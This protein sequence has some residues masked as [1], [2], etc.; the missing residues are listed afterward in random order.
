[1]ESEG[2]L[3]Q[4]TAE[5]QDDAFNCRNYSSDYQV[6]METIVHVTSQFPPLSIWSDCVTLIL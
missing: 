6:A 2:N 1:V 4:I 3:R 5:I